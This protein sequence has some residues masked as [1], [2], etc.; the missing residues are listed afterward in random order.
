MGTVSWTIWPH[1]EGRARRYRR[2]CCPSPPRWSV[3]WAGRTSSRPGAAAWLGSYRSARTRR[4]RDLAPW[5]GWLRALE[6]DVLAARRVHVDL[7]MRHLLD[8]GAAASQHRPPPVRADQLLYPPRRTRPAHRQ[9]ARGPPHRR[10]PRPH[11]HRR[12]PRDQARAFLTA[13]DTDPGPARLRTA[14][15]ARLLLHLELRVDELAAADLADLGHDR[16][17]RVLTVTRRGGRRATVLLPPGHRG[18]AG[19]LS[20]RPR[21]PP[22]RPA[23]GRAAAGHRHPSATAAVGGM[24]DHVRRRSS[25]LGA[26]V[27]ASQPPGPITRSAVHSGGVYPVITERAALGGQL[28]R[29][30]PGFV[31]ATAPL[32]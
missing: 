11:Q 28:R 20:H 22:A 25:A 13:A 4:A 8:R 5:L 1:N 32:W 31:R 6:V 9:P 30:R 12:P 15:T 2:P 16:G 27:A 10:R 29:T 17:H 18:R 24:A 7:W 23:V 26:F 19:R 14:A 21:P 3:R